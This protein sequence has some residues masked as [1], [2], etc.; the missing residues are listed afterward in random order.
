MA[1]EMTKNYFF[2]KFQCGLTKK[3]TAKLCFKS[4]RT[5]TRWDNGQTIPPEC[6]RLMKMYKGVEL[7]SLDSSWEG[8]KFKKGVLV[9]ELGISISPQQLLTGYALIEIGERNDRK[10]QMTIIKIARKLQSI[11]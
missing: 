9:N 7:V 8:W 3:D 5:V 11:I 10:T 2:R 1:R 4:V 6:R